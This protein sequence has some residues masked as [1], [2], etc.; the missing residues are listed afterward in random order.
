MFCSEEKN[1]SETIFCPDK[2]LGARIIWGQNKFRA[3]KNVEYEIISGRKKGLAPKK[4]L[5]TSKFLVLGFCCSF[6]ISP[7]DP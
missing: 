6:D 4:I 7:L 5:R 1:L 2:I 3:P